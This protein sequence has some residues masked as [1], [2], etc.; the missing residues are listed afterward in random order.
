MKIVRCSNESQPMPF[1]GI[2][3][4]D[5]VVGLRGAPF[6][7]IQPSGVRVSLSDVTLLAPCEP[8]KIV[9][10]GA[11]YRSHLA[12]LG[13]PIPKHPMFFLKAP[14]TLIGH[15]QLVEHTEQ[16]SQLEFEA[17]LAIVLKKPL[18]KASPQ[19]AKAAIF[20][21]TCANDVTARDIQF[22]DN[23]LMHMPHAKSF[24]TF[25]PVGP[26][27]ETDIA[28]PSQLA[29]S[30]M[31]NGSVEQISST[32]DMIF[33]V[34][35]MISYFSHIMTLLPGDL[36]LTGTPTTSGSLSVDDQIEI[37]IEGIGTLSNKVVASVT[38]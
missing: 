18:R 1:W 37:T 25:C 4:G 24:D 23:S 22:R 29:I 30:S 35:E 3:E 36:I 31:L 12:E 14:N 28:D 6:E 34:E 7:S 38:A 19:E 16:T 20:G 26:W 9:A 13:L 11:N 17:E 5:D 2:I 21:Y 10:G 32:S 27:I 33:P 8:S 15:G